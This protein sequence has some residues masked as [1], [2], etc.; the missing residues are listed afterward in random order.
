M[1]LI[2][3][4]VYCIRFYEVVNKNR[5]LSMFICSHFYKQLNFRNA[6]K[7]CHTK[8]IYITLFLISLNKLLTK[9][10]NIYFL[11]SKV[12]GVFFLKKNNN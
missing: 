2:K 7:D 12:K 6:S 4:G 1:F 3:L 9:N 5:Q 10:F 11:L 8:F